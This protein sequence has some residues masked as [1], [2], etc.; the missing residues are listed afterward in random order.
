MASVLTTN[1]WTLNTAAGLQCPGCQRLVDVARPSGVPV[2]IGRIHTT[3]GREEI[4]IEVGR[5][6][7]HRC[8]LCLDGEWR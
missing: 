7:V 6:T 3:D 2:T 5:V 8:T 1:R 4:A